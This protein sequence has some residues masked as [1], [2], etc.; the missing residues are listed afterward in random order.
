MHACLVRKKK[1]EEKRKEENL[2][3]ASSTRNLGTLLFIHKVHRPCRLQVAEG[4]NLNTK[5]ARLDNNDNVSTHINNIN[6]YS[7]ICS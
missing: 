5:H 7:T 2:L 3:R 6:L 4:Q 1:K